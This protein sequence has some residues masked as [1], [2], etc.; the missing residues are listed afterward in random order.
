VANGDYMPVIG[1]ST[2]YLQIHLN[3]HGGEQATLKLLNTLPTP[4]VPRNLVS[5]TRMLATMK[6][7]QTADAVERGA[8]CL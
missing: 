2:V 5:L 3:G 6:F 4:N 7:V 8:S 1:K